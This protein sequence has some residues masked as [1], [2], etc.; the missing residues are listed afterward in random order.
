VPE[1][2]W[3]ESSEN[4]PPTD[5]PTNQPTDRDRLTPP[6]HPPCDTYSAATSDTYLSRYKEDDVCWLHMTPGL[7]LGHYVGTRRSRFQDPPDEPDAE[8]LR[9]AS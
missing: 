1:T 9:R 4:T 2:V 3:R 7:Q 6:T 8:K 5:R